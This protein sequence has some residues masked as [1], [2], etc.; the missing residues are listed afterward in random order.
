MHYAFNGTHLMYLQ[1]GGIG[2]V[3]EQ[4]LKGL[5]VETVADLGTKKAA[6]ALLF[7]QGAHSAFE[8]YMEVYLGIGSTQFD[9]YAPFFHSTPHV[10]HTL[11]HCIF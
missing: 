3:S 11:F 2:P 1:I 7:G 10:F 9:K 4:I 8:F 5:H 6:L